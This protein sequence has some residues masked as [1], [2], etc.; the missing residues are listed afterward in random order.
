MLLPLN[1]N[2]RP[3]E[4]RI[5]IKPRRDATRVYPITFLLLLV[6]LFTTACGQ[7]TEEIAM[8]VTET[9]AAEPSPK[10]VEVTVIHTAIAKVPVTVEVTN[11]VEVTRSIEVTRNVEVTRLVEVIVTPTATEGPSPTPTNTST[12]TITPSPTPTYTPTPTNTPTVT[13]T[14]TPTPT[15]TPTFEEALGA[16]YAEVDIRKLEIRGDD[17]IGESIRLRGQIFNIMADGV[18]I[19]VQSPSGRVAV[20]IAMEPSDLPEGIYE[21]SY[22]TVYGLGGGTI[23]GQNAFGGTVSQPILF[24]VHVQP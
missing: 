10:A 3:F 19:W 15:N 4:S 13:P 5:F 20:A 11:E 12:P 18:Q 17:Y 1:W 23:E 16:E 14:F 24:A 2:N 21:D 8:A 6:V 22:I 9:R 7:S